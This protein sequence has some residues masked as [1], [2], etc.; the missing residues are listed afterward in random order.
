MRRGLSL[1]SIMMAPIAVFAAAVAADR[2]IAPAPP[3]PDY[4]VRVTLPATGGAI[5]LPPV[6]GPQDA[7]RPLVLID[8]GHG[9]KDP[10]AG[11]GDIKEKTLTLALA[12]ALRDALLKQGGIRVALTR[13]DDRYLF[14]DERVAI[15]H[16]MHPDLF[17][18]IHADAADDPEAS[19]ATIYTLSGRG[20]DQVAERLAA[21][22]NAADTVNGVKVEG[23]GDA[24]DAILVDLS[25]RETHVRSAELAS[26]ILREGQGAI[27]FRQRSQQSAAFVVL[28]SPDIPS[29]LFETGYVSNPADVAR[30]GSA[31]G[32]DAFADATARAIRIFFARR[33]IR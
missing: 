6:L 12:K 14:L 13:S 17:I 20:S 1:L 33:S 29:I 10:G 3:R 32:R 24:V 15:A 5:G 25:Q 16:A 9:G 21:R 31:S 22:E 19:G 8:P 27:P 7:S 26:L 2:L 4:V 23:H 18:S 11:H 30:L 28:K